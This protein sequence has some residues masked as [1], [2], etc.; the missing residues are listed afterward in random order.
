MNITSIVFI[1]STLLAACGH[2]ESSHLAATRSLNVH[3]E[4]AAAIMTALKA[5]KLV[6]SR[7]S[8]GYQILASDLT[9][10]RT[11]RGYI[12]TQCVLQDEVNKSNT[13][14]TLFNGQALTLMNALILAGVPSKQMSSVVTLK[15]LTCTSGGYVAG[16]SCAIEL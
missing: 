16:H 8:G 6:E 4:K 14:V 2:Q 5:S 15:S 7:I 11:P 13:D 1:V 10:K 3:G 12:A 9:C